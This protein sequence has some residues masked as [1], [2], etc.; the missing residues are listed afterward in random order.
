MGMEELQSVVYEHLKD[1]ID[2]HRLEYDTIYSE[3]KVASQLGISR[4]PMRDAIQRLVQEKYIEI[5]PNKGFRLHQLNQTDIIET[6]QIR[7]ALE[8]YCTYQIAKNISGEQEQKLL[9][10]L[11]T[12]LNRQK[13]ILDTS[14]SIEE[15]VEL[16][17]QFHLL[18][19]NTLGNVSFNI[20]FSRL[21]HHIRRLAILSL[22]HE[23]RMDE[24]YQEHMNIYEAIKKGSVELAYEATL[25]HMERP[26][27]INLDDL[28]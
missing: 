26:K 14:R 2:N 15:F 27:W 4:T 25:A 23:G 10:S 16:D 9:I 17:N 3:R 6:Y 11:Q 1:M 22:K 21:L 7:S 5:V 19:V 20:S 24:T 12:S 13:A 28:H 8:G 18:I